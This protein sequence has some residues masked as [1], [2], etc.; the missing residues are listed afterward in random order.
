MALAA[1]FLRP[2]NGHKVEIVRSQFPDRNLDIH[3]YGYG[4]SERTRLIDNLWELRGQNN[5]VFANS[6]ADVEHYS[7]LLRRRS[8]MTGV[9]NEFI[10]HHAGISRWLRKYTE[11]ALNSQSQP[12]TAVC[13][14]TLELGVDLG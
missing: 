9:E 11:F 7:D 3:V 10:P 13:T 5:L 8:E 12:T 1:E 14:S 6:K 4:S 2:G